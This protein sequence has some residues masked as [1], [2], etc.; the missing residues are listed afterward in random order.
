[1]RYESCTSP[2]T[3]RDLDFTIP[4]A[5]QEIWPPE[6]SQSFWEISPLYSLGCHW[7]S[8]LLGQLGCSPLDDVSAALKMDSDK[9]EW[10]GKGQ[11]EGF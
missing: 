7:P 10:T 11:F 6:E 1:M 2:H 3:Q 4:N 8:F 9:F 5:I